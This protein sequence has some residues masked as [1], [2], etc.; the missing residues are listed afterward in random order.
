MT[1]MR[2]LIGGSGAPLLVEVPVPQAGP[3][4]VRIR[5]AAAGVNPFDLA[6]AD[7]TVADYGVARR[8]ESYGLGFDAAGT[9]DQVGEGA[10]FRVG[11]AVIGLAARLE[12]P[13]KAQAEYVVLDADAVAPAPRGVD[14]VAAATLPLNT[15]TAWQA[16]DRA[17]LAPGGT[18]LVTGAAGAVGGHLVELG[19]LRGLRVVAVA[20]AADEELVREL[21][22]EWFVPRGE[23][24]ADR[25]RAA[26]PG[27]AD[28]AVDAAVLG[29]AA[30]DAVRDGGR[31]VTLTAGVAPVGL[32]GIDVATVFFRADPAQ[33]REIVRLVEAGLLTPRVA[34]TYP[35]ERAAEAHARLAAGGVRGRLVLTL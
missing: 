10:G 26:V 29:L 17:S 25:V 24:L 18:L 23:G 5:V 13:V 12:V 20:G 27:G 21:G 4:Q 34:G 30:L 9:V 14:P 3:G 31:F 16:L 2:A 33:L 22:A 6:I 32:R 28:A 8:L 7:G 19:R 1:N 15:L 11:E 35:L